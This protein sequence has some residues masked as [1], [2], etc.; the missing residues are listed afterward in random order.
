MRSQL[1]KVRCYVNECQH[2]PL[3]LLL[4]LKYAIKNKR[5]VRGKKLSNLSAAGYNF[6]KQIC[7]YTCSSQ[8]TKFFQLKIMVLDIK[9]Y[10]LISWLHRIDL[11]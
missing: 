2:L 3:Y 10:L 5:R 4:N 7:I 11:D 8:F 6:L 9:L 1:H